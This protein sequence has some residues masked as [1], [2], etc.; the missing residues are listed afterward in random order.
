MKSRSAMFWL[1]LI[2]VLPVALLGDLAAQS[3]AR[4]FVFVQGLDS[5]YAA[6]FIWHVVAPGAFV[7]SGVTTAPTG[8]HVV[9]ILLGL[10]K[11]GVLSFNAYSALHFVSIGGSWSATYDITESPL[12]W[13]VTMFALGI[14]VTCGLCTYICWSVRSDDRRRE[15]S[16]GPN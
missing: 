13:N 7:L 6:A 11:V 5:P 1:R 3:A 4:L 2:L 15:G 8:R 10:I 12:W 14:V 9:A 16:A